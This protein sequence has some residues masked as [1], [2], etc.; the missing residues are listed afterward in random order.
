MILSHIAA[1]ARNRVIGKNNQLP[2]DLPE[3]F[4]FFKN[5]TSGHIMIMGRKT[6]ESLPGTLPKRF[7]I[8]ISRQQITS[9]E[10]NVVFVQS[11]EE[12][13]NHAKKIKKDWPEEVFIIGG[14][15][16]YKQT[17][18]QTDRIYLTVIEQDFDGDAYYPEFDTKKFTLKETRESSEKSIKYSFRTYEKIRQ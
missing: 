11:F 16:I 3:D 17:L 2:W 6:F 4:K 13:L 12:A 9:A 18:P 5:K 8:V 7:H 10:E 14:G 1:M 15:E